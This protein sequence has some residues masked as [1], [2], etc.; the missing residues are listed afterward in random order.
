MNIQYFL[1]E[2]YAPIIIT[3]YFGLS[4][5]P[6]IHLQIASVVVTLLKISEN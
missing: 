4:T 3:C 1:L 5:V 6:Q 2:Y